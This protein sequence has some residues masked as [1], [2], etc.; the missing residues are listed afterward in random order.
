VGDR[1]AHVYD[2]FRVDRP[3][4]GDLLVRAA[5]DRRAD[6]PETYGWAAMA[7]APVAAT[8]TVQMGTR[9]TQPARDATLPVRWI[10]HLGGFQGRKGDGEPGVTVLWK[11]FQELV[12]LTAM[13]QIMRP[14]PPSRSRILQNKD[15]G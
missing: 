10:A 9:A 1:E 13:Y 4:G 2:L 3:V 12:A 8:V 14:K 6:H 7:T 11:G 5:Q 15:S